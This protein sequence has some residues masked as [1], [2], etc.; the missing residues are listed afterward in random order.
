MTVTAFIINESIIQILVM[1]GN[2]STVTVNVMCES[3][4]VRVNI[5]ASLSF[6][7]SHSGSFLKG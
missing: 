1:I 3:R 2:K 6:S 4:S 7:G 5:P